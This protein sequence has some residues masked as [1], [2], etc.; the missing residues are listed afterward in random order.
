MNRINWD[1]IDNKI[2][3]LN[4]NEQILNGKVVDVY[5]GDS[6]K[7]VL[8]F[9]IKKEESKY[10]LINKLLK[11]KDIIKLYK[12]NCRLSGIDTPEIRTKNLKEKKLGLEVRNILRDKI[13][14]N[15]LIVK[16]GTFD[17]YGRLLVTLFDTQ[18][19]LQNNNSINQW[20]IDNKYA[21]EYN[22]GK[23][24]EWFT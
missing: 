24:Q 4:F 11:K 21:N 14:N 19:N 6:I 8:P 3:Y 5:D 10:R 23:K 9:I 22:G 15:T 13:L 7:L 2:D 1:I 12:W 18:E 17:K 16:C 20:L